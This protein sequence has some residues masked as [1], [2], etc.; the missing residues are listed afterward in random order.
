MVRTLGFSSQYR[1]GRNVRR[2]V[3]GC[4]W[5]HYVIP[6]A[7]RH[8]WRRLSVPI[9]DRL[10][11]DPAYPRRLRTPTQRSLSVTLY[12]RR[13]LFLAVCLSVLLISSVW[14]L[15]NPV[16]SSSLASEWG[17]N[18]LVCNREWTLDI[19]DYARRYLR[20]RN[21]LINYTSLSYDDP[22][23]ICLRNYEV[24]CICVQSTAW[25]ETRTFSFGIL[26]SARYRRLI[27]KTFH[28]ESFS[29]WDWQLFRMHCF[30]WSVCATSLFDVTFCIRL[31]L[32]LLMS[33]ISWHQLL[34][35]IWEVTS[36]S[37]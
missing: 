14:I 8:R 11:R 24:N 19:C 5:R 22:S 17:V 23:S 25:K 33:Y 37:D 35:F 13:K 29:W 21:R 26:R 9:R 28:L 6:A 16:L 34:F 32:R 30:N 27:T 15:M 31:V 7:S 4:R 36:V 1:S 2:S 10:C 12:R 18:V 3:Y 20:V